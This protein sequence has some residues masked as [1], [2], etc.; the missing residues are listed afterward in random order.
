MLSPMNNILTN[1]IML[2]TYPNISLSKMLLMI[3]AV[4]VACVVVLVWN[5]LTF[6]ILGG[7]LF[8]F[9][10]IVFGLLAEISIA[11]L[12]I[13]VLFFGILYL[14]GAFSVGG[15]GTA[16]GGNPHTVRDVNSGES[17]H[18]IERNGTLYLDSGGRSGVL[19]Q[20]DY[21]GRYI[22]D[23]GNDYIAV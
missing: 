6:G 18:V 3:L 19:R 5:I 2:K 15:T 8:S 13:M 16:S 14:F 22:D 12:I 23:S 1:S 17:F 7:I 21:A 9:M 10:H 20:S 11:A 4:I